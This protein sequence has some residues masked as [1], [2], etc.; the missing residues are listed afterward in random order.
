[1]FPLSI[2]QL[3]CHCFL[4]LAS[5]FVP[6]A[7]SDAIIQSWSS[8]NL[9]EENG[10]G[11]IDSWFSSA[12]SN[13][14]GSVPTR[15]A[16]ASENVLINRAFE[17]MSSFGKVKIEAIDSGAGTGGRTVE[18]RRR[19]V[20]RTGGFLFFSVLGVVCAILWMVMIGTIL[21]VLKIFFGRFITS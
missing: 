12:I 5:I 1:M 2:D 16:F 7:E 10:N 21:K 9:G 14:L 4:I 6:P 17:R 8:T 3:C 15:P 13:F 18:E 11:D 19:S 20:S